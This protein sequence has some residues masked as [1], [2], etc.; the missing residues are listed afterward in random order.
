L[1][2]E[3]ASS[4]RSPPSGL[5]PSLIATSA[6]SRECQLDIDF[7]FPRL[8]YKFIMKKLLAIAFCLF[9]AA[10]ASYS[11]DLDLGTHASFFLP[12]EGG[13]GNATM[14]GVDANYKIGPYFSARGSVDNSNYVANTINYSLTSVTVTLIGH[15]LGSSPIDPY[16][17]AGIG[18]YDKKTNGVSRDTT[19]LN[20]LA[21]ISMNF[22]TFTAGIEIKYTLP[23]T[24]YMNSGFYSIGGQMTG[25]MHLSL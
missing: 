14:V 18:F 1:I 25:G 9:F 8:Y 12:P 7:S 6:I 21:G 16:A 15:L 20:A 3:A 4:S 19:G 11:A 17:G 23:D 10:S 24:R 2:L 13:G 22:Q 5:V